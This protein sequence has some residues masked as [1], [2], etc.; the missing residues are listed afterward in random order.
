MQ[1]CLEDIPE[2][3]KEPNEN[4]EVELSSEV[5]FQSMSAADFKVTCDNQGVIMYPVVEP[6]V[7]L[8]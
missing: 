6:A 7:R 8:L 5:K 4:V 3:F 2:G 1:R